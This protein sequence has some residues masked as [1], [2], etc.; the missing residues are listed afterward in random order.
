MTRIA[1]CTARLM[2]AGSV[3]LLTAM[4]ALA[5]ARPDQP[6]QAWSALAGVPVP[7]LLDRAGELPVTD[8]AIGDRP[9]CAP[10]AEITMVLEHDFNEA[11]VDDRTHSGTQLWGSDQ[12]GTWTL[13]APRADET[14]CIIASGIGFHPD[15]DV[16]I[17]YR[18][19]GL[20]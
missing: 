16:E 20:K 17:Y 14:S 1:Q 2:M 5:A 9:Y 18:T 11:P 15:R 13:V 19:A 10:D 8:M 6:V 12:L 3:A 7:A 4:P